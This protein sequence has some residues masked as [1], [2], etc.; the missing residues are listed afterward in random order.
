MAAKKEEKEGAD[1]VI[2]RNK[3]AFHDYQIIDSLEAGIALR[4]TEV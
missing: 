2:A 1:G 3:K 4:G